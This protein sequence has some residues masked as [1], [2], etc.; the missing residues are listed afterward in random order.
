MSVLVDFFSFVVVVVVAV[1]DDVDRHGYRGVCVC[2]V[3]VILCA[4]AIG[5]SA[6]PALTKAYRNARPTVDES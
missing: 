4:V 1:V 2:L 3:C 6:A 5:P